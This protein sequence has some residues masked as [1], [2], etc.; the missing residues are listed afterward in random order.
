[1][2]SAECR[3]FS[4]RWGAACIK[5]KYSKLIALRHILNNLTFGYANLAKYTTPCINFDSKSRFKLTKV[6][7]IYSV[8]LVIYFPA[9][10]V[11]ALC[12]FSSPNRVS[13][14]PDQWPLC[15]PLYRSV[16]KLQSGR[17]KTVRR[18][19]KSNSRTM[20]KYFATEIFN[21]TINYYI[22]PQRFMNTCTRNENYKA[23][24]LRYFTNNV[25]IIADSAFVRIIKQF[26]F[27]TSN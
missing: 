22:V 18:T 2:Q 20:R 25:R 23:A 12:I 7:S 26:N 5:T 8:I 21:R 13:L 1:M 27:H 3:M 4:C 24:P 17:G 6:D 9:L 15:V 10:R 19:S 16:Q 11:L 14:A